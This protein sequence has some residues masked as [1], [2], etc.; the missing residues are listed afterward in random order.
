MECFK[1]SALAAPWP[2]PGQGA[3]RTAP[4]AQAAAGSPAATP[5]RAA[6]E[7]LHG[8]RVAAHFSPRGSLSSPNSHP[9]A[10]DPARRAFL[11]RQAPVEG[12]VRSAETLGQETPAG[13]SSY[14]E[15][16]E[17]ACSPRPPPQRLL[18]PASAA[19]AA[20]AAA[21]GGLGSCEGAGLAGP[22]SPHAGR[23]PA[24]FAQLQWAGLEV[25]ATMEGEQLRAVDVRLGSC[26]VLRHVHSSASASAT[27]SAPEGRASPGGGQ[28][29]GSGSPQGFAEVLALQPAA[30]VESA[31]LTGA[32][33]EA[34][35]GRVRWQPG[36]ARDTLRE[37]SAPR[38]GLDPGEAAPPAHLVSAHVGQL[39]ATYVPGFASQMAAFVSWG[40]EALDHVPGISMEPTPCPTPPDPLAAD[41]ARRNMPSPRSME[42]APERPTADAGSG[43]GSGPGVLSGGVSLGLSV[44]GVRLAALA[45]AAPA[46]EAVV[47]A[48][49]RVSAHLGPTRAPART[50]S[51]AAALWALPRR[52]AAHSLRLSVS[53]CLNP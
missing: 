38:V 23:A 44:L 10:W 36:P 31:A 4:G 39:R 8:E 50:R 15:Q 41:P 7:L 17:E 30:D 3:A 16:L 21:A 24:P 43:L 48:A 29:S 25:G 46:A 1:D 45:G 49:E 32:A 34:I 42:G 5:R 37:T 14:L 12:F 40:G 27:D 26:T 13:R 53:G 11:E 20:A 22:S 51:L 52:P 35:A 19:L 9:S 6:H 33:G 2:M 28:G 18:S 47:V